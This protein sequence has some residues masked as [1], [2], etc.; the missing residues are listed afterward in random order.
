[1]RAPREWGKY[2]FGYVSHFLQGLVVGFLI[3]HPWGIVGAAF[4]YVA[5][6]VVEWLRFRDILLGVNSTDWPSRDIGDFLI[7]LWIGLILRW[8]LPAFIITWIL[9]FVK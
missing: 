4:F 8:S 9:E 5:Y 7:G 3:P 6:Q 2:W 1:M